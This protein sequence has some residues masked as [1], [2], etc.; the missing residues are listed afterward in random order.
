VVKQRLSELVQALGAEYPGV[1]AEVDV[2]HEPPAAALVDCSRDADL[3]LLGRHGHGAP[4]GFYLGP[5]ARAMI[6]EAQCPVQITPTQVSGHSRTP[7]DD[8]NL[9]AAATGVR[10]HGDHA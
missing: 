3:L 4:L 10:S 6:W 1:D 5:V 7:A 8:P 9:A 2:R